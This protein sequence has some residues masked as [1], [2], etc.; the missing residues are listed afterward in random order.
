VLNNTNKTDI[1]G[2]ML[3]NINIFLS[4]LSLNNFSYN[5]I[6]HIEN[7]VEIEVIHDIFL[8]YLHAWLG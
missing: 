6:E 4:G 3:D 2:I 7:I 8:I 5:L 1:T